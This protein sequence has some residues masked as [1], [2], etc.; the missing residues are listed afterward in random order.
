MS[1]H[2]SGP[3]VLAEDTIVPESV[4]PSGQLPPM[5]SRPLPEAIPLR[6]MLGPSMI[7]AGLALGSGEFVLWPYITYQSGFVFFWACLLGVT[8]QYFINMEI[9]RWSLATGESAITGFARLSKHWAWVFLFLNIVPWMIPAWGTGAAEIVTWLAWGVEGEGAQYVIPLSIASLVVCGLILTAGKVVYDTVERVQMVLVLLVLVL[10]VLLAGWLLVA[11]GRVDAMSALL[12]GSVNFGGVPDSE[13]LGAIMLLGALAFA[14]VGGTLNLGQSNYV[15]DKGYGMGKYIGRI[16]SPITG[17]EEAISE[18]GYHFPHDQEN[19]ARWRTWWRAA[20]LEHFL[21]FFLTCL[22]CIVLLTLIAYCLFFQ[23]DGSPTVG[24]N[25]F[26]SGMG[27]IWA[28]SLELERL[29]GTSLVRFL[30]LGMGVAILLTTEFGVLDAATRISTDI[31]K[32][33]WLRDSKLWTESRLYYLFLWGLIALGTII[34]IYG[35]KS[36][37]TLGLFKYTAAMNG[38]VMFLYSGLLLY[39][40]RFKLPPAVRMSAPRAAIMVWAVLFFGY[41]AV[42][43]VRHVL[44][45]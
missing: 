7:L 43:A 12:A 20:S 23:A 3:Q 13:N 44:S 35:H 30:F 34:L 22:V 40:N 41:F 1:N 36:L 42:W 33:N 31:V 15:K 14:G 32:V 18:V 10:V 26:G 24:A 11:E 17:Q 45:A 16:T 8:T 5:R 4:M 28:Q 2:D 38:G 19:L 37:G 27:F 6:R 21:S 9:T 29:L 39:V 25:Q